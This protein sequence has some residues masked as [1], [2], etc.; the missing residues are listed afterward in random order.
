GR[1]A[2]GAQRAGEAL[3]AAEDA[4]E[5]RARIPQRVRVVPGE[6]LG[7]AR[8][9]D[10]ALRERAEHR[11]D[12]ARQALVPH[13]VGLEDLARA[14]VRAARPDRVAGLAHVPAEEVVARV[15]G[16]LLHVRAGRRV[17]L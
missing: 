6:Q 17:L 3:A 15:L 9:L 13:H 8:L 14:R 12:R 11:A 4:R 10:Q 5:A 7:R 16:V 1:A 2:A